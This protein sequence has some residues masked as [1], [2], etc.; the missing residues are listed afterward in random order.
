M[1]CS[2]R[3]IRRWESNGW[4]SFTLDRVRESDLLQA[5]KT[6]RENK[7]RGGRRKGSSMAEKVNINDE[8]AW[9]EGAVADGKVY[10]LTLSRMMR[11]DAELGAKWFEGEDAVDPWVPCEPDL[12]EP[13]FD[14]ETMTGTYADVS[15]RAV[16]LNALLSRNGIKAFIYSPEPIEPQGAR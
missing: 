14:I 10:G 12:V 6:A 4:L 1:G 9:P 8:S 13:P 16:H 2:L 5:E 3:T 11:W 15:A 7:R